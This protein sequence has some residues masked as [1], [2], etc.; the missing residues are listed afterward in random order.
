M[1]N[2]KIDCEKLIEAIDDAKTI[3]D[4]YDDFIYGVA[5]FYI[6]RIGGVDE[7]NNFTI[8]HEEVGEIYEKI[9]KLLRAY[10]ESLEELKEMCEKSDF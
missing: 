3:F 2:M 1:I 9:E 6:K 8:S 10:P 5:F 7:E 4:Y